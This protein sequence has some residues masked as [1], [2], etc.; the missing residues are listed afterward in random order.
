MKLENKRKVVTGEVEERV[1]RE[2][3]RGSRTG[4]CEGTREGERRW[5]GGSLLPTQQLHGR[6]GFTLSLSLS[7]LLLLLLFLY[8]YTLKKRFEFLQLRTWLAAGMTC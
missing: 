5:W 7:L 3:G 4:E 2:W 1:E 6:H 8:Y